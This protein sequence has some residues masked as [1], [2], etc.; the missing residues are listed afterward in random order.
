MK[1]VSAWLP[2]WA[3]LTI[4]LLPRLR[5]CSIKIDLQKKLKNGSEK[6]GFVM[7]LHG[8][9]RRVALELDLVD[10]MLNL[11][12]MVVG[13]TDPLIGDLLGAEQWCQMLILV[14]ASTKI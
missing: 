14:I 7:A 3:T 6:P 11:V 5:F 8:L 2:L 1:V 13:R 4:S 12:I 9:R 10:Q